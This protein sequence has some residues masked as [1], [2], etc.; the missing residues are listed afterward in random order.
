[1]DKHLPKAR[2][3]AISVQCPYNQHITCGLADPLYCIHVDVTLCVSTHINSMTRASWREG[4]RSLSSWC[5]AW[6][7]RLLIIECPIDFFSYPCVILIASCVLL[8]RRMLYSFA[9]MPILLVAGRRAVLVIHASNS[10]FHMLV[11]TPSM[12]PL[13]RKVMYTQYNNLII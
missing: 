10:W 3:G 11:E 5:I 2:E 1:M 4:G 13:L 6:W 8:A 9:F 12:Q 7:V